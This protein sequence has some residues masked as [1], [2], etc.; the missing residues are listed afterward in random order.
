MAVKGLLGRLV[1]IGC[2]ALTPQFVIADDDDDNGGSSLK[3]NVPMSTAQAAVPPT[4]VFIERARISAV[5]NKDLS[6]VRVKLRVRP[7]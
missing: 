4:P 5:F 1:I 7:D 3:F 2:T 6:E